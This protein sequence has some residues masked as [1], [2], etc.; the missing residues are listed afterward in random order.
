MAL[1]LADLLGSLGLGQQVILA[2]SAGLLVW[3]GW[4]AMGLARLIAGFFGQVTRYG[5]AV[6]TFL[7]VAI[8][9]GWIDPFA[10]LGDLNAGAA[11]LARLVGKFGDDVVRFVVDLL[12]GVGGA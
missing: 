12:S 7:A 5:M 4:R 3:Y 8:Y 9:F 2:M 6:V 11:E 1:F 10:M